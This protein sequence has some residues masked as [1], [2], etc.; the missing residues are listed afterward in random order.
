MSLIDD[1]ILSG[2]DAVDAAFGT[3]TM[4]CEGQTF[5]VVAS[6][7]VRSYDGA[8]GGLATNIQLTATAQP[9]DVTSPN[10][11]IQKRCTID[12]VAYRVAQVAADA[13]AVHFTLED[14]SSKA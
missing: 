4:V 14:P 8:L 1:F 12:G 10:S 9:A 13:V 3:S 2:N 6:E 7:A 5:Q 11:L